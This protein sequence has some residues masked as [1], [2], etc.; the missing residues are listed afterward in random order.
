MAETNRLAPRSSPSYQ[1][2]QSNPES[3]DNA[4]SGNGGDKLNRSENDKWTGS[5]GGAS[6]GVGGL[7]GNNNGLQSA[8]AKPYSQ[9][10]LAG[11]G[12]GV[13]V[14]GDDAVR[15][16]T[17]TKDS[18]GAA[19]KGGVPVNSDLEGAS[20]KDPGKDSSAISG[21]ASGGPS[22]NKPPRKGMPSTSSRS[23]GGGGGGGGGA[24]GTTGGGRQLEEQIDNIPTDM[25]D[26]SDSEQDKNLE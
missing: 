9:K 25:S 8:K 26:T 4:G 6:A 19:G 14:G 17:T 5:G 20:G 22:A 2:E 12:G 18:E 7:A 13:V 21:S 10:V 15:T 1:Q 23:G 16:T 3:S 24:A 11:G